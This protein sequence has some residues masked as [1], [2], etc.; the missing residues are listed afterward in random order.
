MGTLGGNDWADSTPTITG[1]IS[2]DPAMTPGPTIALTRS[3][4]E[5]APTTFAA[6]DK[7]VLSAASW[8]TDENSTQT[9]SRV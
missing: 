7:R 5:L 3:V 6:L 4:V 9:K 1:S 8:W 2:S